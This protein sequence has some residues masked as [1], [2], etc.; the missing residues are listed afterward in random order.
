MQSL[1]DVEPPPTAVFAANDLMAIGAMRAAKEGGLGVP[2][3]VSIVGFDDIAVA[4]VTDPPMTTVH[5]PKYE[6]GREAMSLLIR[7]LKGDDSGKQRIVLH[8]TFVTRGSTA[9]P[10]AT[11]QSQPSEDA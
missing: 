5:V 2:K 11:G 9:P 3:E 8:H 4:Q 6:L 7:R 1:L 10:P